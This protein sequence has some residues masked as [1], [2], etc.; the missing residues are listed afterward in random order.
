MPIPSTDI[1]ITFG[2]V[3]TVTITPELPVSA[4]VLMQTA[5]PV[6][7][8]AP[9]AGAYGFIWKG[10]WSDRVLYF[11]YDVVAY[12]TASYI[13]VTANS[14]KIPGTSSDWEVFVLGE[15]GPTGPQGPQGP[16][17]T[18][19]TIKGT[20]DTSADLSLIGNS[21]GDMWI[22]ADTG[23]GW[24]WQDDDTWLDIGPVQGPPGPIGPTGARGVPGPQ[25]STGN[26]GSQ[27]NAGPQGNPGPTGPQGPAGAASTVPGPQGPAGVKGDTG[28]AGPTGPTGGT[29]PQGVQGVPGPT[30]PIGDTGLTGPQGPTGAASTVPGPTGPTGSQGPPGNTGGQ[31]I[32]GPTGPQG[33][34]GADGTSVVLKGSVPTSVDLPASGN[35]FGDLWVTTDTGDGWVWSTPGQWANVGPIQGPAGPQGPAGTTGAQG[36][37]GTTGAQGPTGGTG[38][39]GSQGVQGPTGPT[40]PQGD[41]GPTGA[42]GSTGPIGLTG[43]PGPQGDPGP[44]GPTGNT[45]PTG[46]A[47]ADSTVPGPQ[48]PTGPTGS[49]GPTGNTGAQGP[50][51]TPAPTY[52]GIDSVS[53]SGT[54]ISLVNDSPAPGN[55]FLYGT[56]GTGALGWRS[57]TALP[58]AYASLTGTPAAFT[59]VAHAASHAHGGA[60]PVT[61]TYSDLA[62][63]PATFA[64]SAHAASHAHG[65]ADPVTITYSD[66]TGIPAS[67]APAAHAGSHR[68]GGSDAIALDTLAATTDI[69]TLNASATAHGLLPKLSNTATQYL[70]GTGGWS[71]VAYASLTGVPTTF[72][73]DATAMLKSVYDTNADGIVDKA[74]VLSTAGATHQFWKNGNVWGQV[75][76]T[77]LTSVPTIPTVGTLTTSDSLTGGGAMTGNLTLTLVGDVATPT[78]NFF[79]G[80]VGSA[81]GWFQVAY[82]TLSG[83]PSTFAPTAHAA[84]HA[85]GAGDAVT[86]AESQVTNLVTDLAGKLSATAAAGGD[87]TGNYPNPT[88]VATA[89]TAGSFTNANI[90]VDAKGRL[91]AASNGTA[92]PAASSTTPV[93][94]GTGTIGVGTT[95]ARADHVHPSDT[96]RMAVGAA[97]TAHATSHKSGGSDAI[98][99]DT[100]AATTDITTLN[101]STTAH[102]LLPKLS[103]VATQYLNGTGGW[104][105]PTAGVTGVFTTPTTSSFTIPAAGGTVAIAIT[106]VAW[107]AKGQIFLI[108]DGTNFLFAEL[109]TRTSNTAWTMT[110]RAYQGNPV[111]GTMAT[112]ASVTLVGPGQ[113]TATQGGLVPAPPNVATQ[114]LNGTGVFSTPVPPATSM[115]V[116]IE[117]PSNKTYVLDQDAPSPYTIIKLS[118]KTVSGTCTVALN[119][120][121]T[122]ITSATAV[123]VTSTLTTVV[124]SQACVAG[125]VITLVVSAN[126]SAVDLSASVRVQP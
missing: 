11:P 93:M 76:Y 32:Q 10:D 41:P 78:A 120:N 82:S 31:G 45:G 53:I 59:P 121:G 111:S 34:K 83:I 88:L 81:R 23:H 61:I 54:N 36:P 49:Q 112:A 58:V 17:G 74:A 56:N 7:V 103:N 37:A 12:G 100:L 94:D 55:N 63:I 33:P 2:P 125:D 114:F 8:S 3:P 68:S 70:N 62:G 117:S 95:Y 65:G 86:L 126:S 71:A 87:L 28:T 51:G 39:A 4:N 44:T 98:A 123:S 18:G 25:G 91:T 46:P 48:G 20:V 101:A 106:S 19:V 75:D 15:T 42:S 90:T 60:D 119:R 89:V 50:P 35:T 124:L 29:G 102:G 73:P 64:P 47:G 80:Y 6:Y 67:F 107:G 97:P 77:D 96:G 108:S 79:Y 122:G 57:I 118:I 105:V 84:S 24:V 26:T 16:P 1:D 13:S 109:T 92:P 113:M 72:A 27:G 43:S 21:V 85:S 110:G 69:T 38:P 9:N 66:L 22:A 30:G 5:P 104:T 116:F 99:L 40:G 14:N 52:V 115:G